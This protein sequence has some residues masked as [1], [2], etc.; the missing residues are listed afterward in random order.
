[1]GKM[2]QRKWREVLGGWGGEHITLRD[3]K[4][5]HGRSGILERPSRIARIQTWTEL[6]KTPSRNKG[7][8][9]GMWERA[10]GQGGGWYPRG[11]GHVDSW[12]LDCRRTEFQLCH[13]H[14]KSKL[15]N[16]WWL[17]CPAR[18]HNDRLSLVTQWW[19]WSNES[20]V[21][22]SPEHSVRMAM[23]PCCQCERVFA[24]EAGIGV[25]NF[26]HEEKE[27]WI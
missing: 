10:W 11:K 15:L 27:A 12:A 2:P 3:Q 19:E 7:L 16:L 18:E 6:G 21:Q 25:K 20:L 23:A 8:E 1:M 26:K 22:C 4:E 24:E 5:R 13:D 14:L 17:S 9:V